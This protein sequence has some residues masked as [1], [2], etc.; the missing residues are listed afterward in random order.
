LRAT[1]RWLCLVLAL[2]AAGAAHAADPAAIPGVP[3]PS[4]GEPAEIVADRIDYDRARELYTASGNVRISQGR[5]TLTAD[6]VTFSNATRLGAASGDVVVVDGPDT[7]RATFME[8]NI[9]TLDGV[10]FRG[11]IDGRTSPFKMSGSEIQR[12]GRETYTFEDAVFTPCR[13]P[14]PEDTDPWQIRAAEAELDDEGYGRAK[15]TT[16]DI[17]GVPVFYFPYLR[18]PIKRDRESGFLFPTFSR[19]STSGLE[20]GLPFF[21]AAREDVG[22]ILTPQWLQFRGFKPSVDAEWVFGEENVTHLYGSYIYD[23]EIVEDDPS[24]PFDANRWAARWYH[25]QWLPAR[26]RFQADVNLVSDNSY[27]FDFDDMSQFR[28]DR[29]LVSQGIVTKS[30]GETGRAHLTGGVVLRDDLQNPDNADRDDFSLQR[31]P[32]LSLNLLPGPVVEDVPLSPSLGVEYTHFYAFSGTGVLGNARNVND[33]FYDTGIDGLPNGFEP[34]PGGTFLGVDPSQDDFP[35]GPEGDFAFEDGE[36]LANRG[37]RLLL[38]PRLSVPLRL[39]DFLEVLP[40]A[41]YRETIYQTSALGTTNRGYA[42]GRVDLRTRFR[43]V[44]DLPFGIGEATHL[45]EPRVGYAL[46]AKTVVADTPVFVPESTF[47]QERLRELDLDNVTLDPA[48]NLAKRNILAGGFNNRFYGRG[49]DDAAPRL[50]GDLTVLS[51]YDFASDR[52]GELVVDGTAYPGGNIYTRFIMGYQLDE[53]RFQEAF[54]QASW[55]SPAGND[56]SISYRFLDSIPLFFESFDSIN[57]RY[58]TFTGTFSQ[59]NQ[60]SVYARWA[61]TR[62]WAITYN[63]TYSADQSVFLGNQGGIEYLSQ[64]RCWALRLEADEDP[65][66]GVRFNVRYRLV[67]LGDDTV[68]PFAGYSG[69]LLPTSTGGSGSPF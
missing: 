1:L 60:V 49:I 58:D 61:I 51:Q 38:N 18:Y 39:F 29:F 13:C 59:V 8:F 25:D 5:R 12:K 26:T 34:G 28:S 45:L 44:L 69:G 9:D 66:S 31:L 22:V 16:F 55:A 67:G 32:T 41:G 65:V 57:E 11:N 42:T 56:L 6:W 21:W 7:M 20:L 33:V 47:D 68:R 15:H 10:V 48:D 64:C 23:N 52:A 63:G 53:Q 50:L 36:L 2:G 46:V 62:S 17:L 37:H 54:V 19:S 24:T 4:G 30:F 14:D 27:A 3:R 35:L 40:E 43:R